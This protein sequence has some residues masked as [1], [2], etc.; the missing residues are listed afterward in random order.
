MKGAEEQYMGTL[1]HSHM[2]RGIG[3]QGYRGIGAQQG[4][5]AAIAAQQLPAQEWKAWS[6]TYATEACK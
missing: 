3:A 2:H 5:A 6:D 1:S 4:D